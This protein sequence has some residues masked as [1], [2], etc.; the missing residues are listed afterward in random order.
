VNRVI[1]AVSAC[2]SL[3][4]IIACGSG[5]SE[6]PRGSDQPG[7]KKKATDAEEGARQKQL[8]ADKESGYVG[9]IVWDARYPTA[10]V[11]AEFCRLPRVSQRNIAK[12]LAYYMLR[13]P[14][15]DTLGKYEALTLY[16]P[17]NSVFAKYDAD[18][19]RVY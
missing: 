14:D 5:P 3:A 12:N 10:H 9:K 17:D 1:L 18:G 8:T 7:A 19:Y 13:V 15:D 11:T 6:P 4:G 2:L 16:A